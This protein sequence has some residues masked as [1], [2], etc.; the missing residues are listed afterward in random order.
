MNLAQ[1]LLGSVVFVPLAAAM[2][3]AVIPQR[4]FA[5][6]L[7]TAVAGCVASVLLALEV[8]R[9][10]P[11][12]MTLGG[13]AE[14]VGIGLRA[15]GMSVV[16]LATAAVVGLLVTV[17]ASGSADARGTPFFWPLW[18]AMWAGL[19]AVFV[20]ADLFNTYV[21]L[22]L[23]TV[24]G[25][26]AVALGGARAAGAAL[27]YL[28]LAVLGSLWF[29]LAVALLYATTGS[30]ALEQVS[31]RL[32]TADGLT[33]AVAV[34]VATLGLGL[35][36]ALA[37]M[38]AWLPP[39]HAGA[40]SAVSP[41][42]S[43]LVV[44]ASLF[45]LFRLWTTLPVDAA[46]LVVSQVVGVLGCIAVVWGS[47]A[48]LRQDRLKRVVAYSTVAQVG[49]FV[50]L[51]PLTAPALVDGAGAEARAVA[52]MAVQGTIAFVVG[53][54]LAKTA[55]FTAAGALLHSYGTDK[56]TA[57]RGAAARHPVPV[58][59]FGLASIALAGLPPAVAFA[60][61]WQ[62][63]TASMHSGQW[64]WLPVL[65]GGGLLTAAYSG[66]VLTVMFSATRTEPA[67]ESPA[68]PARMRYAALAAAVAAAVLGI[69]TS[70]A[71]A[72]SSTGVLG[73]AL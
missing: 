24:A 37:P 30:L 4:G 11:V 57:M 58:M 64:W 29:L 8:A 69:G 73:V 12:A 27:R 56:L 34:S 7:P 31:S 60:G 71:L 47:V 72:L 44:K 9:S 42:M 66:R 25:V 53:H 68:D 41:L 3:T 21:A 70:A 18:L 52:T 43:A 35:K 1:W 2:I 13:W 36:S 32:T 6:G 55:M 48:A 51:V 5:V 46:L 67:D 50:L 33:V 63:M 65:V 39:A 40:P 59:A 20:A 23:V 16:F 19:N 54:A 15:D 17:Y 26:G 10:G 61:K 49:Y 28:L 45:V 38:H 22:E 14:P 62:L